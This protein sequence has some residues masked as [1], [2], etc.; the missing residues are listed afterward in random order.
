MDERLVDASAKLAAGEPLTPAEHAARSRARRLGVRIPDAR[1]SS[2]DD[3]LTSDATKTITT[4]KTKT[5]TT[6][7]DTQTP[8]VVPDLFFEVVRSVSGK[9]PS[10]AKWRWMQNLERE[11][12]TDRVIRAF[13]AEYRID[14][15]PK[16]LCGRMSIGLKN[17]SKVGT[18]A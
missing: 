14:P 15:D 17:G 10:D 16:T 4:T 1:R 13:Q 8:K 3:E 11:F 2:S 6:A 5:T 12:G 7:S 9:A 18:A